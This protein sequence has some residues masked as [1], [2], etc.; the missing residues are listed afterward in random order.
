[1]EILPAFL[2]T[3]DMSEAKTFMV[4][5]RPYA[6]SGT[7]WCISAF[8]TSPLAAE[9]LSFLYAAPSSL[10]FSTRDAIWLLDSMN[11]SLDRRSTV[12][13]HTEKVLVQTEPESKSEFLT[14]I[15]EGVFQLWAGEADGPKVVEHHP[16][17]AGVDDVPQ[18]EVGDPVEE[19]EDVRPTTTNHNDHD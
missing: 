8:S 10:N 6:V 1:M 19:G 15:H 5:A 14:V 9:A 16:C 17:G 11:R 18:A 3:Y 2:V 7:F 12:D 4:L 13:R